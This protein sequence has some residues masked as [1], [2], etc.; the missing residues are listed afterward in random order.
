MG[1]QARRPA[2]LFQRDRVGTGARCCQE[3]GATDQSL[4]L[5]QLRMAVRNEER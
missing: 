3:Q 5:D 4:G 2:N 1:F